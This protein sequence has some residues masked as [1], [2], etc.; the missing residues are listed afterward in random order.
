MHLGTRRFWLLLSLPLGVLVTGT[1]GFMLLENLSF[2]D[3]L[4]FTMVTI[5]TVGYGDIYPTSM[6]AKIFGIFLIIIGIGTFLT[7]V[8][9]ATQA[10]VQRGEDKVRRGRLNMLVGVFFTEVGNQLLNMLAGADPG[11]DTIRQDLV[12][13]TGWS[14]TEFERLKKRLGDYKHTIDSKLLNLEQ[15][16]DFLRDN[17]DLLL[18]QLE[19][20]DLTEHGSFTELL[21]AVVHLRDEVLAR[22][23]FTKLPDTDLQHLAGDANRVYNLL[24]GQWLEHL[25]HLKTSYPYLF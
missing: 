18:R 4:Y 24:T 10:L 20:S 8:T 14:K 25:H 12:V 7:I 1:A 3:A 11:I 6:A 19:N 15:L 9:T 2:V 21:W 17:G 16:R 23:D 22:Q 13:E 5:S